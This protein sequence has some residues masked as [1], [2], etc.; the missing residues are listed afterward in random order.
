MWST[1]GA[2][3]LLLATEN[4]KVGSVFSAGYCG[5]SPF[6]VAAGGAKGTVAVWDTSNNPAVRAFAEEHAPDSLRA[7]AGSAS[8]AGAAAGVA[9]AAED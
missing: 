6:V 3:P 9:G 5:D 7:A 8:A 4:L 2:A 1:V